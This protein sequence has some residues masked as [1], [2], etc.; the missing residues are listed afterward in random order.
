[1]TALLY[2]FLNEA[3]GWSQVVATGVAFLFGFGF[4]LLAQ[5]FG[6]EEW[7][8]WEPAPSKAGEKKRET[9][10][11]GLEAEFDPSEGG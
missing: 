6:W 5:Y 1:M 2:L 10:G 9:L 8:P 4:R 3:L 11:K 7:E